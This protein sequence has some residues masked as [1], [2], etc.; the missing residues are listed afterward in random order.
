MADSNSA[1]TVA[2]LIGGSMI[3]SDMRELW[4]GVLGSSHDARLA[5]TKSVCW[6]AGYAI[7]MRQLIGD[8]THTG[9]FARLFA[10]PRVFEA[11][12][13][14]PSALTSL[15]WPSRA[16]MSPVRVLLPCAGATASLT[17]GRA[18]TSLTWPSRARMSPA[19]VPLPCA[20]RRRNQGTTACGVVEMTP[21]SAGAR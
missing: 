2:F 20:G 12:Q 5:A 7:V 15:T 19:R 21:G 4:I 13:R 11:A 6:T 3:L 18:A 1:L 17:C 14:L 16:C 9:I 10:C 8:R